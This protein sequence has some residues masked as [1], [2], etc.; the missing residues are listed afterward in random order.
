MGSDSLSKTI[1]RPWRKKH[2]TSLGSQSEVLLSIDKKNRGCAEV[3]LQ[4]TRGKGNQ[5][6]AISR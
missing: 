1:I 5:S 2:R 3:T 4:Q 6:E